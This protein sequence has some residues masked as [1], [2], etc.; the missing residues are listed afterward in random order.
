[1]TPDTT[2]EKPEWFE[3]ADGDAPAAQ[4]K[5][6]NKK[7]PA[8]AVVVTG[9]IIATGAFFANASEE[10]HTGNQVSDGN[11][12]PG[13]DDNPGFAPQIGDT[14][15]ATGKFTPR[16]RPKGPLPTAS[17]GSIL[18]PPDGDF[19][20]D[21]GDGEDHGDFI[22]GQRPPHREDG[23]RHER[24]GAGSAPQIP[25]ATSSPSASTSKN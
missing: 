24:G 2:P 17:D 3:L 23:D 7:L 9:A 20:G 14:S 1:M 5:K 22:P 18:P 25:S 8:I 16:V 21:D 12:D 19:H 6:V 15:T 11:F 10:S 13:H 4:V